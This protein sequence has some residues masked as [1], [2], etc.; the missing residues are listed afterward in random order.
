MRRSIARWFLVLGTMVLA[1][2]VRA[3]TADWEEPGQA[4]EDAVIFSHENDHVRISMEEGSRLRITS[5][6]GEEQVIEIDLA[7]VEDAVQE[8]MAGV[9]EVLADLATLQIEVQLGPDENIVVGDGDEHVL[10]ALP[11]I[12][13]EV[14]ES[15]AEILADLEVDIHNDLYRV[16]RD[17]VQVEEQTDAEIED[18][19]E[20]LERLQAETEQLRAEIRRLERSHRND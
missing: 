11:E 7:L 15:L 8:A 20:E 10:V 19:Q 5:G 9:R 3:A 13:A 6:N 1:V 17:G 4:K 12:M 14:R 18:L 16:H 2:C